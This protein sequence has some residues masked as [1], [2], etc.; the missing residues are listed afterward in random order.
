VEGIK[1][2]PRDI[3]LAGLAAMARGERIVDTDR[4]AVEAR[5]KYALDPV[6]W[7]RSMAKVM[8]SGSLTTGR[9]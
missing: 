8:N 6:R 1:E 2:D 3:A 7:E 9:G 4:M 5:A